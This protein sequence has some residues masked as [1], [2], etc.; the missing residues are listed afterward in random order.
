VRIR[1]VVLISI[2]YRFGASS[3]FTI[4]A[5]RRTWPALGICPGRR[6]Y[7]G[8]ALGCDWPLLRAR[9]HR[10]SA[11]RLSE[12]GA[13]ARLSSLIQF[14]IGEVGMT[15]ALVK[16][17]HTVAYSAMWVRVFTVTASKGDPMDW[18]ARSRVLKRDDARR[19]RIAPCMSRRL[20]ALESA[21]ERGGL[22]VA[23]FGRKAVT[24][25]NAIFWRTPRPVRRVPLRN[26][27]A[28]RFCIPLG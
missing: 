24:S 6:W 9:R 27:L 5:L 19:S 10:R 12:E 20:A 1:K 2:G 25:L 26:P 15:M 28:G 14:V 13:F 11:A 18:P 16:Y 3:F 8:G 7:I 22:D 21:C 23:R 17:R 4:R